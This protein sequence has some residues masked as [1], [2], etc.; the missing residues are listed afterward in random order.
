ME[1]DGGVCTLL[2]MGW[3]GRPCSGR[4]RPRPESCE[5][6]QHMKTQRKNIL[7]GEESRYKIPEA[8]MILA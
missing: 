7:E 6:A 1:A 3:S 4:G 2:K 8:G 5:G